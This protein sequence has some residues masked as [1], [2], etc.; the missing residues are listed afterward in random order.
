MKGPKITNCCEAHPGTLPWTTAE[1]KRECNAANWMR[2]TNRQGLQEK[3][4]GD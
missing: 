4:E 2:K 1:E 3:I